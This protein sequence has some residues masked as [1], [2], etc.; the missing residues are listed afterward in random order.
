MPNTVLTEKKQKPVNGQLRKTGMKGTAVLWNYAL[1][2]DQLNG[3]QFVR[4]FSVEEH[5]IDFV[6]RKLKLA[7]EI[8]QNSS[9]SRDQRENNKDSFLEKKGYKVL[10]YTDLEITS[11][12]DDVVS[13]IFN[14]AENL[15][16]YYRNTTG[17]GNLMND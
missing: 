16:D 4:K 15:T 6:C 12:I 11:K 5:K 14:V 7:I 2:G 10:R 3:H 1:E 13:D 17:T 9:I 8:I